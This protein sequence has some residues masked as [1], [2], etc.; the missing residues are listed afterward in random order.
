MIYLILCE[1]HKRCF[2]KKKFNL[3]KYTFFIDMLFDQKLFFFLLIYQLK[4]SLIILFYQMSI[5]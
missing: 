4:Y 1:N 5:F 2:E 3:I